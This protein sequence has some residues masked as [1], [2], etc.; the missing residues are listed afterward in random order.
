[1]CD[2]VEKKHA[3]GLWAARSRQRCVG[4]HQPQAEVDQLGPITP[5][6]PERAEAEGLSTEALEKHISTNSRWVFYARHDHGGGVSGF[7][8]GLCATLGSLRDTLA[9]IVCRF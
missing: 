5:V 7:G 2:V 4:V 1:M 8:K 6:V 9:G 3:V